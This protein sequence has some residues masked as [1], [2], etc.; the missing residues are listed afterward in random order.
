[1]YV[2]GDSDF[3]QAGQSTNAQAQPRKVLSGEQKLSERYENATYLSDIVAIAAGDY[4]SVAVDRDGYVYT[5]GTNMKGVLGINRTYNEG[6][7]TGKPTGF[8]TEWMNDRVLTP[9]RVLRGTRTGTENYPTEDARKSA[10]LDPV[11]TSN[12]A[13]IDEDNRVYL[14][15]IVEVAAGDDHVLA[16]DQW[17]NVYAWGDNRSGQLGNARDMADQ[18]FLVGSGSDMYLNETMKLVPMLISIDNVASI[19]AGGNSSAAV[20][21]DGTVW[22]WGDNSKG[23]PP[24]ARA[25]PPCLPRCLC[26]PPPSRWTWAEAMWW[27]SLRTAESTPGA[28]MTGASWATVRPPAIPPPGCSPPFWRMKGLIP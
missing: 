25:R 26:L 17:G 10:I 20:R 27:P 13:D 2:W 11:W 6:T 18:S 4:V 16:L 12:A 7:G 22:V 19:S 24:P 14:T 9:R 21:N 1:V 8:S 23:Q 3:G 5:W 15:N 28:A